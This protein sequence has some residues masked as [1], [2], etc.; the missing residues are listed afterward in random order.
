MKK[1]KV[2]LDHKQLTPKEKTILSHL[3]CY[4][5]LTTNHLMQ[6]LTH[7]NPQRIQAW[8]KHLT[9]DG[10]VI[11]EYDRHRIRDNTKPAGYSYNESSGIN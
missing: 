1:R 7:K 2:P 9:T 4:R 6:L 10:Y 3:L 11:Q 5:F 8:L